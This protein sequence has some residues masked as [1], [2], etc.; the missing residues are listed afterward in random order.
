MNKVAIT[1]IGV[2]SPLGS[3]IVTLWDNL[4]QGNSGI[5]SVEDFE[6]LPVTF[7]GVARDFDPSRHLGSK[8]MRHL[9]RYSQ[10]ALTAGLDAYH[11]SGLNPD[12]YPPYRTGVL[13]GTG[14][15]GYPPLRNRSRFS[16]SAGLEGFLLSPRPC[17]SGIPP[18][19]SLQ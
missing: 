16:L 18:Q 9:D 4:I 14:S 10:M 5:V 11:H 6:D 8:E 12:T 17:L 1:G 2:V 13:I 7:G 3:D 19:Q 15:G